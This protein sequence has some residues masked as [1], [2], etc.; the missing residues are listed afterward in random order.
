MEELKRILF[1]EDDIDVVQL[2]NISLTNVGGYDVHGFTKGTD[3]LEKAREINPQLVLLD[4]MMPEMDGPTTFK[5]LRLLDGLSNTPIVFLTAKVSTA[6][7]NQLFA[8]GAVA[9]IE[10][11]FDPM[12]LPDKLL[13]AWAQ[14]LQG[15]T[16]QG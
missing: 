5:R 7:K 8:L 13:A 11:P 6:E 12:T 1:V 2:L 4:V 10:K 15:I 14:H 3:A 16:P 9:V